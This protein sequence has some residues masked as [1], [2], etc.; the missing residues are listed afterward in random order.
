[1]ISLNGTMTG[2]TSKLDELAIKSSQKGG[3]PAHYITA[4]QALR[5][6]LMNFVEAKFTSICAIVTALQCELQT[7]NKKLNESEKRENILLDKIAG[8]EFKLG[9]LDGQ[10]SG[11]QNDV[12]LIG[13]SVLR[14]VRDTDIINGKV[15]AIP[16]GK[17]SNVKEAIQKIDDK[18]KEIITLDGG[19][20]LD[21]SDS[22]V[23]S[24]VEEYS[25]LLTEIKDK[26]PDVNLTVSGLPPRHYCQEIHTKVKDFNASMSR[27]CSDNNIKFVNN[28]DIFELK[29]GDVDKSSCIM[30][31]A[32]PAIH[33]NRS[34]TLRILDNI[35]KTVPTMKF[36]DQRYETNAK[37]SYAYKVKHGHQ[38]DNLK[39][40]KDGDIDHN[41]QRHSSGYGHRSYSG[42]QGRRGCYNCSELN[43]SLA[44]C[45]HSQKI[46]CFSCKGLGH[47]KKF[48][49]QD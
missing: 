2:M 42:F 16:G 44:Q 33:L 20:N 27:W 30:T 45:R 23:E 46:R 48:C 40:S 10:N 34:G 4:N 47:K 17:I 32:T 9:K 41:T 3:V 36:S 12:L 5:D 8:L 28:E 1:M 15:T 6:D 18:P 31:G 14:E 22:K 49:D 25:L 37:S 19:N 11:S 24:V 13:S 21:E 39:K 35:Q 26:L 38:R 29:S 43:H 7:C